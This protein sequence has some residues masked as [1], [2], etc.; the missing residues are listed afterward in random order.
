MPLGRYGAFNQA[1]DLAPKTGAQSRLIRAN[2]GNL[3]VPFTL[4]VGRHGFNDFL[5]ATHIP[6]VHDKPIVNPS[7]YFGALPGVTQ[8]TLVRGLPWE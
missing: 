3:F 8:P 2:L 6:G 1:G 7:G 5:G 4:V